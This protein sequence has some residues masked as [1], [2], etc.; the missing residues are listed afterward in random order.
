VELGYIPIYHEIKKYSIE[1]TRYPLT[2]IG[3]IY[4]GELF[5]RTT[6]RAKHLKE[7]GPDWMPL[8]NDYTATQFPIAGLPFINTMIPH[9]AR[10]KKLGAD[11]DGDTGSGVVPISDE[12]IRENR[13]F[14]KM[15]KAYVNTDGKPIASIN[16]SLLEMIF[17]NL[18]AG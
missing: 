17:Y 16:T 5:V 4:P 6:V 7:L 12:A 2:G 1:L 8:G 18:S 3:S 13:N 11:F 10:L 9:M 15:K 14:M